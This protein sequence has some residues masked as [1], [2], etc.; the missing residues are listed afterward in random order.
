MTDTKTITKRKLN[1]KALFFIILL[2]SMII[3]ILYFFFHMRIQNIYIQNTHFLTDYEIMKVA[4]IED[5]PYLYKIKS[6]DLERKLTSLDLVEDVTVHKSLLG[7]LTIDITEAKP[8]FYNRSTEKIVL[9]NERQVDPNPNYLG[10]PVLIN[11]VPTDILQSFIQSLK[12]VDI[13]IIHMIN[14]IE[15]N[16]DIS[17]NIVIDNE[18]F[19]LRMNDKN[20]V[21][22]NV[23]NMK[24]LNDYKTALNKAIGDKLGTLY[25]D[26]YDSTNDLV[27]VFVEFKK[28]EEE[29]VDGEN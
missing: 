11:Y 5:Y 6:Q 23:I 14:E 12:D 19:L 17:N 2:C 10:I 3:L 13:D 15:Y 4:E 9:S 24:R 27:G 22:V 18:R 21:Y 25:L 20:H 7:K 29:L 16:P 28:E 26:S 1:K 8:L